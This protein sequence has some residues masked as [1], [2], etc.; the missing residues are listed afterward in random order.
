MQKYVSGL[1]FS[2]GS[3][4]GFLRSL[5]ILDSSFSDFRG[6]S[7]I[8]LSPKT[9]QILTPNGGEKCQQTQTPVVATSSHRQ[10]QQQSRGG[11]RRTLS[12]PIC[13]VLTAAQTWSPQRVFVLRGPPATEKFAAAAVTT[14][15][16]VIFTITHHPLSIRKHI[17]VLLSVQTTCHLHSF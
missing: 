9:C 13:S 17:F 12:E 7:P 1:L 6:Q 5:D 16:A 4:S 15:T 3:K 14:P 10:A 2:W 8:K 11:G